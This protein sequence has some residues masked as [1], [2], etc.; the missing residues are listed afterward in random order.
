MKGNENSRNHYLYAYDRVIWNVIAGSDY[1]MLKQM[2]E[3]SCFEGIR[4]NAI[5]S[6]LTFFSFFLFNHN[7]S[8]LIKISN[9]FRNIMI[10]I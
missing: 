8:N 6:N 10:V 7:H 2:N 3:E 9:G 4:N 1:K 5:F